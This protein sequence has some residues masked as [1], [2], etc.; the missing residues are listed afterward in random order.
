[1][2]PQEE[3]KAIN[4]VRLFFGKTTAETKEFFE[5]VGIAAVLSY[6][7]KEK[8]CIPYLGELRITYDGDEISSQGRKAVI[9]AEFTPSDF[10]VRNVGQIEDETKTDAEE[11]LLRR[12]RQI[13]KAKMQ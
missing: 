11:I 13:F 8:I 9:K 5:S 6:I 7:K 3:R 10:I 1:M 4:D 2:T 12:L